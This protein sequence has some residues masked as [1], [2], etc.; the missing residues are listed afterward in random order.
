MTSA[1][2]ARHWVASTLIVRLLAVGLLASCSQAKPTQK[3]A[4]DTT[5]STT[6]APASDAPVAAASD[7]APA[8]DP[9]AIAAFASA[10]GGPPPMEH[11][12]VRNGEPAILVFSPTA[13]LD[14]GSDLKAL[15][16][17]GSNK[18]DCHACSGGLAVHYLARNGTDWR[19]VGQ[20]FDVAAGNGFGAPPTVVVRQD[21]FAGPALEAQ[22]GW[23]GQGCTVSGS[24]LIEL[25]PSGPVTRVENVPTG[26]DN[27]GEGGP[28]PFSFDGRIV[29]EQKGASF[30]VHYTGTVKDDVAYRAANAWGP[31]KTLQLPGC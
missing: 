31:A 24:Q 14:L 23:A 29:A 18:E 11:S 4:V 6:A 20:W 17:Q 10:W 3:A 28:Q 19:T 21:L 15:I 2:P 12:V 25:T 5:L 27:S 7:A 9:A 22:T 30:T 16:S 13:L 26:A 1:R 8:V